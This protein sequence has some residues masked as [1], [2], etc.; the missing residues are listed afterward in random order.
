MAAPVTQPATGHASRRRMLADV[1]LFLLATHLGGLLVPVAGAAFGVGMSL[2]GQRYGPLRA[3]VV[4]TLLNPSTWLGVFWMLSIRSQDN[5]FGALAYYGF[6][7]GVLTVVL[8]AYLPPRAA[9]VPTLLAASA[10]AFGW[11]SFL[12]VVFPAPLPDAVV[13]SLLAGAVGSVF[14]YRA[15]YRRL[16][17]HPRPADSA[18]AAPA[19]AQTFGQPKSAAPTPLPPSAP[20][21]PFPVSPLLG[22]VLSA[23]NRRVFSDAALLLLSTYLGGAGLSSVHFV[24]EERYPHLRQVLAPAEPWVPPLLPS[25]AAAAFGVGV[26]LL[27]RRHGPA[28]AAVTVSVLNPALWVLL[29]FPLQPALLQLGANFAAAYLPPPAAWLAVVPL[30][31]ATLSLAGLLRASVRG[32]LAAASLCASVLLYLV[33]L[34]RLARTAE[35]GQEVRRAEPAS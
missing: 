32:W 18:D 17:A 34:R 5:P 2:L 14:L 28:P 7:G 29:V 33:F 20:P 10:W 23:L 21:G 3:A 22:P 27:A 4:V 19:L 13:G 26:S 15:F 24:L 6:V 8:A 12:F 9:W 25:L 30:S 31:H 35:T 16:A 11:G 1:L